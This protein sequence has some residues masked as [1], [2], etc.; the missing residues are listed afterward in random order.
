MTTNFLSD[1]CSKLNLEEIN[2]EKSDLY[3]NKGNEYRTTNLKKELI[4]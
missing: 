4:I 1:C 3:E 2:K